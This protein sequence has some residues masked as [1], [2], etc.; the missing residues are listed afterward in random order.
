MI[1]IPVI[2][3]VFLVIVALQPSSYRVERSLAMNV[4]PAAV[5]PQ[6]NDLKKWEVWNPWSKADPN[7]KLTFGNPTSGVGASY[8]WTGNRE[9]GE[10]RLSIV[11]SRPGESVKYKLEF[12]K[13]MAAVSETEFTFKTRGNQTEVTSV[14]TGEKNFMSKAFCLFMS[15]DKMIGTKFEK[16]LADLQA[17]VESPAK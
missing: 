12:V 7:I 9:M 15:M 8:S 13:P 1:A 14:M 2:I 4:P 10:G 17:I 6:V 5:F 3:V 11:E 16:A